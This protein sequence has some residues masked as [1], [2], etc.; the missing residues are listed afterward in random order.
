MSA[1]LFLK[2][3]VAVVFFSFAA[4][5]FAAGTGYN[6]TYSN[7]VKTIT[8]PP[9]TAAFKVALYSDVATRVCADCHSSDY[10]TT[11]PFQSRSGWQAVLD[12]MKFNFGMPSPGTT[13][14]AQIIDYLTVNYGI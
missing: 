2:C 7:G 5:A 14:E 13:D 11:Q 10:P 1:R 3:S 6:M 8:L 4:A 9:E 12:K